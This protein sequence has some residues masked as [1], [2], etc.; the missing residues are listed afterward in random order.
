MAVVK[1]KTGDT[2]HLFSPSAPPIDP[3][4]EVTVS[5]ENFVGRAWPKS[6]WEVIEPPAGCVDV[7][8]ED[9]YVYEHQQKSRA[10]KES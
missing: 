10:K 7:G 3:G 8:P 6:T 4:G 5:D 1:N 2:L 9:A